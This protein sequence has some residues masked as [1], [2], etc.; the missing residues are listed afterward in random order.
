MIL[1]KGLFAKLWAGFREGNKD[2]AYFR[3][4]RTGSHCYTSVEGTGGESSYR[5]WDRALRGAAHSRE[6]CRQ[7]A[8]A[9]L[10]P[11]RRNK[12]PASLSSLH[13]LL[14]TPTGQSQ[15]EAGGKGAHGCS[16]HS[17]S[18]GHGAGGHRDRGTSQHTGNDQH[19]H[20]LVKILVVTSDKAYPN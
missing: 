5:S 1:G 12:Y 3:L 19:R 17:P 20:F 16:P 13:L 4:V 2:V 9:W 14:V 8:G 15:P 7:T 6:A 10:E 11:N 18:L